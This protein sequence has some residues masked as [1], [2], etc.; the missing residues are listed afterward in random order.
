[1][2]YEGSMGRL[3]NFVSSSVKNQFRVYNI[4]CIIRFISNRQFGT[5]T[6]KKYERQHYIR[7]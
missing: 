7:I 5:Y 1:M 4:N 3:A 2:G 6:K